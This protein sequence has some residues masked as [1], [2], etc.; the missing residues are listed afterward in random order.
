MSRTFVYCVLLNTNFTLLLYLCNYIFLLEI[1]TIHLD[2]WL[3]GILICSRKGSV[4]L[5]EPL[6]STGS[7]HYQDLPRYCFP[8]PFRFWP[9]WKSQKFFSHGHLLESSFCHMSRLKKQNFQQNSVICLYVF[10]QLFVT[11]AE[12]EHMF[13]DP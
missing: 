3:H 5:L 10:M 4:S 2:F 7:Y 6:K 12:H 11:L 8:E 1:L 9:L 13:T